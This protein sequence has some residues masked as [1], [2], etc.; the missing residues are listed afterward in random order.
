MLDHVAINQHI[1]ELK[2]QLREY[3]V[4]AIAA[5]RTQ[6]WMLLDA[7][8]GSGKTLTALT[9]TF[10]LKPE[11]VL[12]LCSK[13]ALYTWQKE[14]KKWYPAAIKEGMYRVV[15]GQ[16][17][18]RLKLWKTDAVFYVTTFQSFISDHIDIRTII[19]N[20]KRKR[21]YR[22]DPTV[23]KPWDVVIADEVH[24]AG[25]RNYKTVGYNAFKLLRKQ[26][27]AMFLMTGT[28]ISKGPEQMWPLLNILAP[29]LFNS[30][31]R[32]V[33]T[34]C[35]MIDGPF[36]KMNA[37]PQ[38]T[39]GLYQTTK[40]VYHRVARA[41]V[42]KQLPPLVRDI[43]EIEL[44]P[45]QEKAYKAL[46]EDMWIDLT[47]MGTREEV[48][49]KP[50][51]MALVTNTILSKITRLR[52]M[53]VCPRLLGLENDGAAIEMVVDKIQEREDHH[54]V[55][56]TPFRE[57]IRHFEPYLRRELKTDN[58]FHLWGSMDMLAVKSACEN[59][60]RTR[61]IMLCSVL[62]AQSFEL[63]TA[64]TGFFIGY[65]WD[66]NNNLQA[67]ARLRRLT[68]TSKT[69]YMHYIKHR[70]TVEE[71]EL[72]VLSDKTRNC[73]VTYTYFDQVKGALRGETN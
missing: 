69:I 56:F 73:R 54:V 7:W 25:L 4:A 18:Q 24:R 27:T 67:E 53:C 41:D 38:N 11:R 30:Y 34:Y 68:S 32:F 6:R 62:F 45:V 16:K 72:A 5:M 48:K 70:N 10:L 1:L 20:G 61:G 13:N 47:H 28:P 26:T 39:E 64:D 49:N 19:T 29:T 65:D 40:S 23:S 12:I 9:A 2:P 63:E 44:N 17:H 33:N 43:I 46:D 31:W 71:Q 60:K 51:A 36:G 22:W 8:M 58:V 3:Q 59:F 15:Q 57:A 66:Q 42:E 21:I 55:I 50:T 37:G 35:L 52:Q 14:M